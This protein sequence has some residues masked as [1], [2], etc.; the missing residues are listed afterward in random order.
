MHSFIKTMIACELALSVIMGTNAAPPENSVPFG[1]MNVT[2]RVYSAEVA[3]AKFASSATL[4]NIQVNADSTT[5]NYSI[6]IGGDAYANT[7]ERNNSSHNGYRRAVAVGYEASSGAAG[8]AIGPSA[9]SSNGIA[10]IAIGLNSSATNQNSISI[11]NQSGRTVSADPNFLGDPSSGQYSTAIGYNANSGAEYSIAL[12]NSATIDSAAGG[13]VAIGPRSVVNRQNA[14]AMGVDSS[15]LRAP[16]SIVLGSSATAKCENSV[17]SH[18]F[19]SGIAVGTRSLSLGVSS[20]AIGGART[21]SS[22]IVNKSSYSNNGNTDT[23]TNSSGA[24]ASNE[25]TISIGSGALASSSRGIAIGR[26]S[27][28]AYGNAIAIGA[29]PVS[30]D[31]A[32]HTRATQFG[33]IAIGTGARALNK[34]SIALGS[35]SGNNNSDAAVASG[36]WAVQIGPGTNST[37]NSLQFRGYQLVDASGKIPAARLPSITNEV[38]NIVTNATEGTYTTWVWP[39]SFVI[40]DPGTGQDITICIIGRVAPV[41]PMYGINDEPIPEGVSNINLYGYSEHDKDWESVGSLKLTNIGEIIP[42][43][44]AK[45]RVDVFWDGGGYEHFSGSLMQ[46]SWYQKRGTNVLGLARL[47]DITNETAATYGN[48]EFPSPFVIED[49]W[50][51]SYSVYSIERTPVP[52]SG[53][54]DIGLYETSVLIGNNTIPFYHYNGVEW[55][56][57]EQDLHIEVPTTDFTATTRVVQVSFNECTG[58]PIQ[59]R[60]YNPPLNVFGLARLSDL[61]RATNALTQSSLTTN[62]VCGIVTNETIVGSTWVVASISGEQVISDIS[63]ATNPDYMY[64]VRGTAIT[65]SPSWNDDWY[66]WTMEI[67]SYIY[68]ENQ[69][70]ESLEMYTADESREARS[71]NFKPDSRIPDITISFNLE[72]QKQNALGLARLSDLDTVTHP[73]QGKT[74]DFSTQQGFYIAVSNVVSLLG[75]TITNFPAM[76]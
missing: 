28:A 4:S 5:T 73:L 3:D 62:A 32:H 59:T 72:D 8:V 16:Y 37:Q 57:T 75:G 21:Y 38:C 22:D 50:G 31:K 68:A 40:S 36:D 14:I 52:P 2:T 47:I 67:P 65:N 26:Y 12:G 30:D 34:S 76:P 41:H 60:S 23:R 19:D 24:E 42:G 18:N 13:S 17:P 15:S 74:F 7:A 43:S 61:D 9:S 49:G 70:K 54:D 48:W 55:E 69:W 27:A 33:A 51:R 63:Q 66:T 56:Y 11:G 29:P 64:F 45:R 71:L 44:P 1:D 10:A 35:I 46:T 39:D 6:A 25:H 58:A 20:I 53:D